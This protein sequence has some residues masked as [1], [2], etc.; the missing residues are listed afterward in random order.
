MPIMCSKIILRKGDYM[1]IKVYNSSE[2]LIY[3]DTIEGNYETYLQWKKDHLLN[4]SDRI[5]LTSV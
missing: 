2:K 1:N 5:V 3:D 4:D